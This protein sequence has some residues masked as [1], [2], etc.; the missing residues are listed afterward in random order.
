MSLNQPVDF[1]GCRRKVTGAVIYWSLSGAGLIVPGVLAALVGELTLTI[2][3]LRIGNPKLMDAV[4]PAFFALH[5]LAPHANWCL[6]VGIWRPPRQRSNR[7][8]KTAGDR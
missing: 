1:T 6:N 4:T 2:C 3:R 8:E 7:V 5:F